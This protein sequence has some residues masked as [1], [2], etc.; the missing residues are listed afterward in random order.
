MKKVNLQNKY[1]DNTPEATVKNITNFF[2]SK[3]Y[4]IE[5][6]KIRE[7]VPGVWWCRVNLKYNGILL[8]GSNGKGTSKEYALASGHS[9]LYERYCCMLNS[10]IR[11]KLNR[12][13]LYSICQQENGYCLY[14]D[15]IFLSIEE[16]INATLQVQNLSKAINDNNNSFIKYL[17]LNDK[18]TLALPFIGFNN[19]NSINIPFELFKL[20]TGSSGMAAG[21]TIEE[22][23]TQS[24]SE[25]CEHHVEKQIFFETQPFYQINLKN[26]NYPNY[27]MNFFNK[28]E[29]DGYKYYVYDFS[30][31]YEVPVLGLLIVDQSNHVSYLNLGSSPIF[32]IALERCC[33]EIFQG[34]SILGDSL[35]RS[36]RPLRGYN[37][38]TIMNEQSTTITGGECYPE[39]LILNSIEVDEY[40]SKIF[41]PDQDYSNLDLNQYYKNLFNTKGWEVYYRDFSQSDLIK[42]VWCCIKNVQVKN[43]HIEEYSTIPT[44]VKK[45]KWNML[46][47]WQNLI[48]KYFKEQVL[49][50]QLLLE[51]QQLKK[52]DYQDNYRFITDS[53]FFKNELM[54]MPGLNTLTDQES[55]FDFLYNSL[56]NNN[57]SK[58]LRFNKDSN[59]KDYFYYNF[60]FLFSNKYSIPEIKKI[61][62]FYGIEY[63]DE[64]YENSDNIPYYLNKIYFQPYYNYYYSNNYN[65][66]IQ[67]FIPV[68]GNNE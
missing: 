2:N 16:T 1:K 17:Q 32:S 67:T 29:N 4:E 55:N 52:I 24:C 7:P 10:I 68:Q 13:K 15:E 57:Y 41:L 8:T 63:T 59:Y 45:R 48:N 20:A 38:H 26:K 65:N 28:L 12:E 27:I 40:N 33:T 5:V 19:N 37:I 14:P 22:A 64:D 39:N 51:I 34:Y 9:E 46:F 6:K 58:F 3:G 31:L 62:K 25:L 49:D 18:L 66:L 23:L 53:Q 60:L 50:E 36:M 42:A 43:A 47:K 61:A 35:K 54:S 56:T 44:L 21:N 11:S 30:Y